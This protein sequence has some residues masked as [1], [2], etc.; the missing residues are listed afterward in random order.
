[1]S[2][3]LL[4]ATRN[5]GKL[6]EFA[7]LF[8]DLALDWYSLDELGITVDVEEKG[9]TFQENA[10]AKA[11]DYAKLSGCLMTLVLR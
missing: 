6:N 9:E 1:M 8:S 4:L 7:A 11:T 2:E 10:I 3:R 5:Q